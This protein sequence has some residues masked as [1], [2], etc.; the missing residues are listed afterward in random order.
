MGN[1]RYYHYFIILINILILG[2]MYIIVGI[3]YNSLPDEIPSH[4]NFK[5]EVDSYSGK[6]IV[7]LLPI[8]STILS[9][10]FIGIC[11]IPE[12]TWKI[13][14]GVERIELPPELRRSVIHISINYFLITLIYI[15]G[16]LSYILTCMINSMNILQILS[17]TFIFGII[18]ILMVYLVLLFKK[19][20]PLLSQ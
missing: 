14:I 2:Y 11:F 9:L 15:N 7:F 4:F 5:G 10:L 8:V 17:L 18:I 1:L 20:G 19:I 12:R 3:K 16:F 13:N 6:N